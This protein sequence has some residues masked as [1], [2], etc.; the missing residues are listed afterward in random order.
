MKLP[1]RRSEL[2]KFIKYCMVGVLNT[3]ITL[4]VIFIAKSLIGLNPYVSNILGYGAGLA[5]SF[6][7]NRRWVFRSTGRMRREAL[8]FLGG[9][10]VCYTLQ[11]MLVWAL[12]QSTFG[13]LQLS[14]SV[15]TITGYGIA[16][17]LGNVLYTVANFLYNRLITFKGHKSL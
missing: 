8:V 9:F 11:F 7:W 12:T 3:L 13:E 15:F 5:N 17:L 1:L 6:L 2:D 16:T 14:I 10:A 4:G